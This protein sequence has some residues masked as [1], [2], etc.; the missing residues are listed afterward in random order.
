MES[1]WHQLRVNQSRIN[2]YLVISTIVNQ[3]VY[4]AR[5]IGDSDLH[6]GIGRDRRP[7][8]SP[9]VSFG[10]VVA[11]LL[12]G[13]RP[14]GFLPGDRLWGFGSCVAGRSRGGWR[15]RASGEGL[16]GGYRTPPNRTRCERSELVL[17]GSE[18]VKTH[19]YCIAAYGVSRACAYRR[20]Y[21]K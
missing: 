3:K 8:F 10:P 19:F 17:G 1:F 2:T 21:L 20:Y 5:K 13:C 18:V 15:W 9:L 6:P 4:C 16:G 7:S 14:F 12:R 11:V